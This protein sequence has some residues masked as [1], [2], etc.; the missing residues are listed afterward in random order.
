MRRAKKKFPETV[1]KHQIFKQIISYHKN[2]HHI[3]SPP[4]A[5]QPAL[6]RS[7]ANVTHRYR[8]FNKLLELRAV[9]L[10]HFRLNLKNSIDLHAESTKV[11][12]SLQRFAIDQLQERLKVQ[13]LIIFNC[14]H[15]R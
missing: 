14:K 5:Q 1:R 8:N 7:R 4:R 11:D 6:N 12:D 9:N 2:P 10:Q 15:V 13:S 3:N